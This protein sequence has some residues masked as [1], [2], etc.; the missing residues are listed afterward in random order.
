MADA[1][2]FVIAAG[3]TG[4][5]IFPGLAVAAALKARGASVVWLGA[6]G[7]LEE[8][9][10]PAHNLPIELLSI[11]AVRGKGVR[12]WALAPLKIS[13]AVLEAISVLRRH[14]P[15]AVLALGG[16]AAGPGGIAA[17]LL[18][19]PLVVHEQN[20]IPGLTNR[21]LSRLA[22]RTLSGF[23]DAFSP[24]RKTEFVGNPVRADI[25]QLALPAIRLDGRAGAL[26]VLVLG[27]SQGARALNRMV[28]DALALLLP[29]AYELWHQ[30]GPKH[31][32]DAQSAYTKANVSG[33]ID[34]FIKDMAAAY[35]WADIVVC[36]SGAL[37]LAELSA[38]GVASILVPYPHAVDDHQTANARFLVEAGAALLMPEAE[39]NARALADALIALAAD[40][41]RLTQMAQAARNQAMPH[42]ADTAATRL[43]ELAA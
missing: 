13:R 18:R 24:R 36:R 37:T 19:R 21:V 41:T 39:L 7:A 31:L 12:A 1:R 4:G 22:V 42:A 27:G 40:R 11:S 17:W 6:K 29:S 30:T 25:S 35:S 3:G 16:F 23:P 14:R 2:P 8:R 10:V 43:L 20:R 38:A 34:P 9:L 28:P 32:D 26:R 33:R 5:H 15:R